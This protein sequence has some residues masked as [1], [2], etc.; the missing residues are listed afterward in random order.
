MVVSAFLTW[1]VPSEMEA[2]VLSHHGVSVFV[3]VVAAVA[4]LTSNAMAATTSS[5]DPSGFGEGQSF[6]GTK[7]V[8]NVIVFN[9][10][11]V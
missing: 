4:G 7:N 11:A 6:L 1:P 2:A 5:T 9:G 3:S 10:G 8:F